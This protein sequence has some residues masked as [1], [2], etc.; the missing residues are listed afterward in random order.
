VLGQDILKIPFGAVLR[1][2]SPKPVRY[3]PLGHKDTGVLL[4]LRKGMN[5][6]SEGMT[7]LVN[8][9]LGGNF[10]SSRIDQR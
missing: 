10:D 9:A 2:Q 4:G 3:V 1:I 6:S 5:D 7:E 8:S